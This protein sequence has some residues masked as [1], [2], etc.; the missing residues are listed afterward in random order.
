VTDY[1]IGDL[2][3]ASGVTV[4]N[5]RAY[6]ER[7][8]LDPPRRQGRTAWYDEHH[9][10]QLAMINT[11]HAK[12]F[13]SAHIADFLDGIRQ[14]AS[15]VEFLGLGQAVPALT[16]FAGDVAHG[17][18]SALVRDGSGRI[19]HDR[20]VLADPAVVDI[21]G[22]TDDAQRCPDAVAGVLEVTREAVDELAEQVVA[23]LPEE[24]RGVRDHRLLAAWVVSR[25]L[26]KRVVAR[27]P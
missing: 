19:D 21:V 8:L 22:D 7:G 23:A 9:L 24:V 20:V 26:C 16:E 17:A 10:T 6:R 11:L 5:I 2:A 3:H 15:L 25:R 18:R 27:L 4:R 1:R 12:G 14:G 13:T